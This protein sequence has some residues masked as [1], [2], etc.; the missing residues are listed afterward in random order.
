MLLKGFLPAPGAAPGTGWA[1]VCTAHFSSL[2]PLLALVVL[3]GQSLPEQP[4]QL[5]ALGWQ[6]QGTGGPSPQLPPAPRHPPAW[7]QG[8]S[9]GISQQS[10]GNFRTVVLLSQSQLTVIFT[11]LI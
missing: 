11:A 2:R 7:S 1:Q 8:H 6:C 10:S 4:G 9:K 5:L 3:N